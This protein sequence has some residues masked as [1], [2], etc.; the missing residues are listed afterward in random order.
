MIW[1]NFFDGSCLERDCKF[2]YRVRYPCF[3]DNKKS[4]ENKSKSKSKFKSKDEKEKV[5]NKTQ[6]GKK[7][8]TNK[9]KSIN[10][11]Y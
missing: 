10:T 3:D 4:V 6:K 1:K 7:G 8:N 9:Q 11:N 5:Q 2:A